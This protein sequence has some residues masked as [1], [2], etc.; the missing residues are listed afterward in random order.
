MI[1]AYILSVGGDDE[2]WQQLDYDQ[3]NNFVPPKD[4]G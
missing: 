1:F 4:L 3:H 2:V